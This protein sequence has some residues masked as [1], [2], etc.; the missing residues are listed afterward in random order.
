MLVGDHL[1]KEDLLTLG[2]TTPWSGF[3]DAIKRESELSTGIK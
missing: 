2:D 3:P 1:D